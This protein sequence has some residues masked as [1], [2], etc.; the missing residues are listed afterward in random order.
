MV[1]WILFRKIIAIGEKDLGINLAY[2]KTEGQV[3]RRTVGVSGWKVVR[4][5]IK[6]KG[7]QFWL[8]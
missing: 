5:N 4:G 1:K 7:G 3:G 2:F 6:G 8:N